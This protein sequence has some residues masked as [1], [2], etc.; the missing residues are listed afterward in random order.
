MQQLFIF[1]NIWWSYMSSR[2]VLYEIKILMPKNRSLGIAKDSRNSFWRSNLFLY[3]QYRKNYKKN[4]KM[5]LHQSAQP[6]SLPQTC[7]FLSFI[8]FTDHWATGHSPTNPLTTGPTIRWISNHIWKTRQ[9][10]T[11]SFCRK[12]TQLGKFIAILQ[13][14]IQK[15]YQFP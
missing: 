4:D 14:I 5:K 11:Y 1:R 9:M 12:Q 7:F 3:P 8:R 15:V 6:K 2:F 13:Y 10:E